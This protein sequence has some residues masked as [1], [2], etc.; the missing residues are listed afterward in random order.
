[1]A[2][3][4]LADVREYQ[5]YLAQIEPST[6]N[7]N[8]YMSYQEYLEHREVISNMLAQSRSLANSGGTGTGRRR[9]MRRGGRTPA[10]RRP[11]FGLLRSF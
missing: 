8:V 5:D 11:S 9:G 7:T 2:Q 3:D 6:M 1:M 4:L 10:R